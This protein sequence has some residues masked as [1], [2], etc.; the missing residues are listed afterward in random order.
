MLCL[1]LSLRSSRSALTDTEERNFP[2]DSP[3]LTC[4][5]HAVHVPSRHKKRLIAKRDERAIFRYRNGSNE[6]TARIT[7]EKDNGLC[8][9]T[10]GPRTQVYCWRTTNHDTLLMHDGSDVA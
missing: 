3:A 8:R 7:S 9:L 2:Q 1:S 6:Q 5:T 4:A 10:R